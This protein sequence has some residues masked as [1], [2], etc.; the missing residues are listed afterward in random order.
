VRTARRNP[1][2]PVSAAGSRTTVEE[3]QERLHV[4]EPRR[5]VERDADGGLVDAA[6]GLNFLAA[7]AACTRAAETFETV[8][9]S[10]T[11]SAF[12]FAPA[13]RSPI[14]RRS[15]RSFTRCAI[16]SGRPSV[17]DG[18]HRRHHGKQHLGVQMFDVALSRRMCCSR[19]PSARRIAGSPWAS[20]ETR[21]PPGIWRLNASFV[22]RKP[23]CG[24]RSRAARRNAARSRRRRLREFARRA[25]QRER[26][27]IGCDDREGAGAWAVA[28]NFSN[29]WI[30]PVV[31]GYCTS[32]PTQFRG[33]RER[34]VVTD[35][36][37]DVERL[38]PRLHDVDRLRVAVSETKKVWCPSPPSLS[39]W[40]IIIASA[41]AVPSSSIEPLAISRPVRIADHCLEIQDRLE[42]ACESLG[43]IGR[44]GGIPAGVF[45]DV[46]L[47]DAGDVR[48]RSSRADE[49]AENLVLRRDGR[50]AR[51]ARRFSLAAAGSFNGPRRMC[52]GTA[53]STSA[54]SDGEPSAA[55]KRGVSAASSPW[56]RGR[57]CREERADR[58]GKP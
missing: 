46:A 4:F 17:I 56:W 26:E 52:A 40:H 39:R 6:Q 43:L 28:K 25:Q 5:L 31:S 19:V 18:I 1:P 24:P 49:R 53:A 55:S 44:V 27:E 33:R 48:G 37:L 32:T 15:V 58:A 45:E 7:A 12:T 38:R 54:S 57:R 3:L 14:A 10:K 50:A 9:V 20:F 30:E 16:F 35:D 22:A 51:Q 8:S 29:P 41:A 34:P 36:D 42:A 2:T 11:G 21:E 23:A 13:V 47:D